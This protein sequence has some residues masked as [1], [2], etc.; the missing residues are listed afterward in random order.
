MQINQF[1]LLAIFIIAGVGLFTLLLIIEKLLSPNSKP[2]GAGRERIESAERSVPM[3]RMV[4]F[5]YFFYAFIF[6]IFEAV[7][8]PLLIITPIIK[9]FPYVFSLNLT[10]LIVYLV[11]FIF[12]LIK[13]KEEV[14]EE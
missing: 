3:S 9:L 1:L 10:F 2:V 8:I 13:K 11:M 4:G 7:S 5:Q 14:I 6:V 12:Y